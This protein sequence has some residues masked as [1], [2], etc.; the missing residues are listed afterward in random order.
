[1]FAHFAASG[2]AGGGRPSL[3]AITSVPRGR[4]FGVARALSSAIS[5]PFLAALI[6]S[7]LGL[8]AAPARAD[9]DSPPSPPSA[10]APTGPVV[11]TATRTPQQAAN[12]LSD[13]VVIDADAISRAGPIALP[14]LLQALGGVEI[15]ANGGPG[16]V[17]SVFIR[18]TNSD[19]VLV[20]VDGV[21]L[22]SA[23]S[24][25]NAFENIPVSQID[26]IEILRGPASS[27]YGA[28][29]IGGVI[30]IFTKQEERSTARVS[31]GSYGTNEVSAGLARRLGATLVS[32][33]GGYLDSRNF[34]ATQP[35]LTD[36]YTG[37]NAG[38]R[39]RNFG[40]VLSQDLAPGQS[41]TLRGLASDGTTHYDDYGA[42]PAFDHE[43]LSTVSLES[44]NRI[45]PQW[46]S[47][48]SL[49]RG[50]DH[51]ADQA[52]SPYYFNTDQDQ[53]SWQNDI[54][55]L[56]GQ[57]AA[58]LEWRREQVASD[59]VFDQTQRHIGSV[60]GSY[61]AGLGSNLL[62]LSLRHDDDSQF[63]GRN[64]GNLAYG[65]RLTPALRLSASVGTA[66]KAPTFN[67]L[68]YPG[69][70]NP[71]LKPESARSGEIAARYRAGPW[72]AALTLFENR[73]SDL[74]Q[75]DY[76]TSMPQNV[77]QARV[78]GATLGA[79][80]TAATWHVQAEWTAQ[81][82]IDESTGQRL[83]RR[84]RNHATANLDYLP[85]N[86]W[87]AGLGLV[88]S[89]ER[90]NSG[91]DPPQQLGGYAL[92]NLHLAYAFTPELSLALQLRN[93]ADQH[94][95]LVQG[96]NTAGRSASVVLDY[97]AR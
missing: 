55:A 40:L 92:L 57:I 1:M 90:D 97:A 70:S 20:L 65:Y 36:Y 50:S 32:L 16:Q 24:G 11:I 85:G 38:Y 71:N 76:V 43:H 95:Q 61:A 86:A 54:S 8:N 93:A 69:F 84:A 18:G 68:Y 48:L 83:P 62:Q 75:Y 33:Q 30:Q 9:N 41:L 51:R 60:F 53:A 22:N 15:A 81:D 31:S 7:F 23:T 17:S 10:A 2:D 6:G 27:L 59:T 25:T 39:N 58:G 91:G 63:G 79:G 73:I 28:D 56:G 13:V 82:A 3:H 14:D 89:S 80:Y 74:I 77:D 88:A 45:L 26:H 67:D 52:S 29:A 34:P 78:R 19:H 66:F 64:T 21:R 37:Q 42:V 44:R 46:T 4:R 94:Y 72:D 5:R 96:Y 87:R 49:A 35:S 12:V 47:Q